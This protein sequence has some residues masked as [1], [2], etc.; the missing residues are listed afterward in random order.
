MRKN[1]R[2]ITVLTLSILIVLAFVAIFLIFGGPDIIGNSTSTS[3]G[4]SNNT[5]Q[6]NTTKNTGN[7]WF[8]STTK[9]ARS[10]YVPKCKTIDYKSLARNPSRYTGNNYKFIGEVIQVLNGRN[11]AVELRVN[12]TPKKY[13]YI[14]ETFYEDTMYVTYQY[15]SNTESR[16]LE[17][18][19][20]TIYGSFE[21]IYTYESIMGAQVSIPMLNA[22]YIDIKTK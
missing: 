6:N 19:I 14:D 20:I 8:K 10:T 18:D 21:G 22:K 17:D 3:T 5:K 9:E 1:E 16:I 7:S 12:V 13:E 2:G 4:V 15:S 11:N